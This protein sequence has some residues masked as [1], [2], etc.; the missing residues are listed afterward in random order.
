[1]AD[2]KIYGGM[3]SRANRAVWC[4]KELGIPYEQ[5]DIPHPEMKE[6][7]F[8]A[9]NPNGKVPAIVDG[10][11]K[12]F[13]SLAINLYLAKRYGLGKLYPSK[14]ED[15]ARAWQWSLWTATEVEP[16]IGPAIVWHFFQRGTQA[17]ADESVKKFVA[18]LHVLEG[19]LLARQWLVGDRFGIADLNVASALRIS[20]AMNIDLSSLPSVSA[21]FE[22]CIDRPAAN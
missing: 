17:E 7:A 10:D 21:W 14:I 5:I 6:A 19:A 4:A 1:M 9:I 13:E 2:L 20:K 22:R 16:A 15:E 3:R 11:L 8:L 18:V 12:L